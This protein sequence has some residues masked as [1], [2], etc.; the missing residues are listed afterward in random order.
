MLNGIQSRLVISYIVVIVLSLS[1]AL[2]TLFL[3]ARPLQAR[4]ITL[5]LSSE[6]N[7]IVT[8][9][10]TSAAQISPAQRS[11]ERIL[12]QIRKSLPPTDG[13]LLLINKQ[14]MVVLD[15]ENQWNGHEITLPNRQRRLPVISR[16][17]EFS[18]KM[19]A[20]NGSIMLF[21]ARPLSPRLFVV[22]AA[23]YPKTAST[24]IVELWVGFLVAG[25]IAFLVAVLMGWFIVRSVATPLKRIARATKSVAEGDYSQQVPVTG[26]AEV[27]QVASAFNSMT[28]Q[29]QSSQQAMKDF[30]SNVSHDLKTPLTAIQ[31]FSQALLDGTA[32]D[33]AA[34]RRA[35]RII[36]DEASRMRR[37]VED[38]LDLARIDAGQIKIQSRP[39]DLTSLLNIT[40]DSFSVQF[41]KKQITLE[42]NIGTLPPIL[43]DA[44][45]LKQVFTNLLDNAVKFTPERGKITVTGDGAGVP[46]DASTVI[47]KRQSPPPAQFFARISITDTGVGIPPDELK[48]IFERFYQVDKSR[49]H[50]SGGAGL[51]LAIAFNIVKAHKGHIEAKSLPGQ[52]TTFIIWL[53]AT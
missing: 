28:T 38:L 34:R 53:P 15:A 12:A 13:R 25:I 37:L 30:V 14:G 43:G 24:L 44:D 11:P 49:K 45:R 7:Q 18:G 26:P 9:I 17:E 21:V 10:Q 46:A 16:S 32:Q 19:T 1:I 27:Q 33:D 40:L 20:P 5:R 35:A 36:N 31:G 22:M 47:R 39:I 48:R 8:Q 23:P 2:F 41:A 42:T 29:V 4:V 51:G 50:H 3:L 52:G 6:L